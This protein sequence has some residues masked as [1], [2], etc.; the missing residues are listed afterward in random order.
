MAAHQVNSL[1]NAD[2]RICLSMLKAAVL[3]LEAMPGQRTIVMVSS[4]FLVTPDHRQDLM[5]V[6]EKA[7]RANVTISSLDARGIWA[8]IP[9]GDAS[10]R[11]IVPPTAV[12]MQLYYASAG[13]LGEV[14][15]AIADGTGGA[16]FHNNNDLQEGFRRT[17]ASPEFVY[18]LGFSPQNLKFDG[19]FHPI[20]VTAKQTKQVTLQA[21]RGYY[22]LKPPND[23]AKDGNE[24]IRAAL[25]SREEMSEIPVEIRTEV[26]KSTEKSSNLAVMAHIDLKHLQFKKAE[27]RNLNTLTMVS[28]VFD[29]N[30]ILVGAEQKELEMRFKEETFAERREAGVSMKISFDVAPGNYIVRLVVRDGEG[31]TM[32]ARNRTVE[33][34]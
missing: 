31:Q 24:G 29:H 28:A 23:D 10:S 22:D 4:G 25:F 17:A 34:R 15:E 14:L 11:T 13:A 19:T 6:I 5:G 8:L 9:G 2:A 1:S 7:I 32:A 20:K 12:K 16:W 26:L 21:R 30:G 18:V 27:G 33:V 3:R